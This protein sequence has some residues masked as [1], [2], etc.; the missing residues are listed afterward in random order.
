MAVREELIFTAVDFDPFAGPEL[1]LTVPATEAQ[2]EIWTAT[3]MG[4]DASCAFNESNT[5]RLA[6]RLDVDALR[7]AFTD[8]VERHSALRSTFSG[9]GA[10]L[11]IASSLPVELPLRDL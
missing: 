9:D 5:L 7:L 8:L 10:M 1:A 3:R 6:G 11:L 2:R 4:R